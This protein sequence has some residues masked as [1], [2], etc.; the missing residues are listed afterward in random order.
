MVMLDGLYIDII[1][2][3]ICLWFV[4]IDFEFDTYL[5]DM[6]FIGSRMIVATNPL[7]PRKLFPHKNHIYIELS[8]LYCVEESKT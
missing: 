7:S 5:V 6:R 1:I 2:E 3:A 4:L 8:I